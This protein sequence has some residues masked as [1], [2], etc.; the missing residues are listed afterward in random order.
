MPGLLLDTNVW[1]HSI[2]I[3]THYSVYICGTP[4]FCGGNSMCFGQGVVTGA[5][6][7]AGAIALGELKYAQTISAGGHERRVAPF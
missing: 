2:I 7:F 3:C 5:G 6:V 4:H 1:V